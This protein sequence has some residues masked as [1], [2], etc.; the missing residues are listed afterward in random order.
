[1]LIKCGSTLDRVEGIY[2]T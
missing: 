1:M 2:C